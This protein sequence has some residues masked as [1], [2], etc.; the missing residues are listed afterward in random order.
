MKYLAI[1]TF[2]ARPALD[3]DEDPKPVSLDFLCLSLRQMQFF[4]S[5]IERWLAEV[6]RS[7][8]VA[9]GSGTQTRLVQL[10][11]SGDQKPA[12]TASLIR[13][14]L[15]SADFVGSR[16]NPTKLTNEHLF[17]ASKLYDRLAADSRRTIGYIALEKDDWEKVRDIVAT[18]TGFRVLSLVPFL[19]IVENPL[20]EIPQDDAAS[21]SDST[22][23]ELKVAPGTAGE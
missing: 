10:M 9:S 20:D 1:R 19:K 14:A 7:E 8:L 22:R 17:V 21:A 5:I 16:D 18:V 6:G 13:F 15:A 11:Q 12:N 3:D 2:P 23:P 4:Y